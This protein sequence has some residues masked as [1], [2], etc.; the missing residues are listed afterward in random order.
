MMLR[1]LTAATVFA[2][3]VPEAADASAVNFQI[4]GSRIF[5]NGGPAISLF[6]EPL[7]AIIGFDLSAGDGIPSPTAGLFTGAAGNFSIP[8]LID[9]P[10]FGGATQVDSVVSVV[11]DLTGDSLVW[12]VAYDLGGSL[13]AAQLLIEGTAAMLLSDAIPSVAPPIGEITGALFQLVYVADG[14]TA[15]IYQLTGLETV[16]VP[17]PLSVFGAA[18]LA[19][20]G[21]VGMRRGHA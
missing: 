12:R 19:L 9:F 18:L 17:E 13:V 15:A 5:D 7:T 3:M 1:T 8:G 10:G 11:D 20:A 14:T 6:P 4:T 21:F 2:L 16:P